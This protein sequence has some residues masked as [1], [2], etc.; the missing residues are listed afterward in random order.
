M[1]TLDGTL[2]A[3]HSRDH[4]DSRK[5]RIIQQL[6]SSALGLNNADDDL[7][8]FVDELIKVNDCNNDDDDDDGSNIV[9]IDGG[10]PPPIFMR[11]ESYPGSW[12]RI[13]TF[14]SAISA[15]N[16]CC[17]TMTFMEAFGEKKCERLRD[18][19]TRLQRFFKD[20]A[21]QF[22]DSRFQP[23]HITS[24]TAANNTTREAEQNNEDDD[25]DDDELEEGE[26][27]D[28]SISN[29]TDAQIRCSSRT[30]HALH[31][32]NATNN[33]NTT[34]PTTTTTNRNNRYTTTNSNSINTKATSRNS[35][36]RVQDE[37]DYYYKELKN[38]NEALCEQHVRDAELIAK[39]HGKLDICR[40]IFTTANFADSSSTSSSSATSIIIR[41][42]ADLLV[43]H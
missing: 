6:I 16:T 22:E 30:N 27:D 31:S 18:A 3:L 5:V 21:K 4:V 38:A 37:D 13:S 41:N 12:N 19:C 10:E 23:K 7:N 43:K 8:I 32:K 11:W 9:K 34:T 35:R 20:N 2:R 14:T 17:L 26:E 24:T 42:L 15:I 28:M 1:A 40:S 33:N 39:L 36:N 29:S 25:D